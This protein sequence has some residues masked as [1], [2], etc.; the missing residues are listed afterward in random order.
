VAS[1]GEDFYDRFNAERAANYV[2]NTAGRA[3][4]P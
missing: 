2:R 4:G 3:G 1:S